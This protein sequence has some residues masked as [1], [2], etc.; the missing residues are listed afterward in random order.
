M[1]VLQPFA[2][3]RLPKLRG[4]WCISACGQPAKAKFP[5]PEDDM[6][7]IVSRTDLGG[8]AAVLAAQGAH[9]CVARPPA[10]ANSMTRCAP[11]SSKENFPPNPSG[12]RQLTPQLQLLEAEPNLQYVIQKRTSYGSL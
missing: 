8:L 7:N 5:A 12:L 11:E 4:G 10:P 3:S 1:S 6:P 2:L 9:G